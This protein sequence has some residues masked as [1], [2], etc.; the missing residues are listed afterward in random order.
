MKPEVRSQNETHAVAA[1]SERKKL[2]TFCLVSCCRNRRT[3]PL[4][5]AR[6]SVTSSELRAEIFDH[7][8]VKI[9]F[10]SAHHF[11]GRDHV[12]MQCGR[13]PT[14]SRQRLAGSSL[15]SPSP[16]GVV[17]AFQQPPLSQQRSAPTVWMNW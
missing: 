5:D 3:E 16:S 14:T 7:S 2:M 6:G 12:V 1:W 9:R 11:V 17:R 10:N 4:A 8:A 13:E 15:E